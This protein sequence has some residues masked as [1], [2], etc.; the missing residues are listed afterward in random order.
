MKKL[1]V[2]SLTLFLVGK[3]FAQ[4]SVVSKSN[5][6]RPVPKIGHM[7]NYMTKPSWKN[8]SFIDSVKALHLEIIRYPGGTE[9]QYFD[10]QT[11]SSVPAFLWLNGTL[12]SHRYI[13]TVP[14]LS[15]PLSELLYFYQQ[16]GVKPIFCLNLLTKDLANQLVML[17]SAKNMGIPVEYIELGNEL[18]FTDTDFIN[19]YPNPI[20]YVSDV[21]NNWLP[22]LKNAFPDAKIAIIGSYDGLTDLNGNN[23]PKRIHT[24]N[25]TVFAQNLNSNAI[26]FHYY[27]PPNTTTL[28]NPNISQAL[29][30]PFRHWKTLKANTVDKVTNGMEC[31]VTEYNLNDGNQTN[32][33][34]ASSWTHG[35]YTA[36][37]YGLMLEEPKITMLL[38]H[39]ITGSPAFASLASYTPFGDTLSNKMTAE[40]NAMR[41][42]HKSIKG[43]NT[44][45]KL[46]FSNN[47]SITVG[48]AVYPS[49][50]GWIFEEDSEKELFILNL[51]NTS[52]NLNFSAIFDD[53][54]SYEQITATN[55]LQKNI[56]TQNLTISKGV[57]N[58]SFQSLPYSLVYASKNTTITGIEDSIFDENIVIYPNPSDKKIILTSTLTNLHNNSFKIVDF[59]GKELIKGEI[60][61]NEIDISQLSIG[62]FILQVEIERGKYIVRKIV[63]K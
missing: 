41:L 56:T 35:L 8:Q 45:T 7:L 12:F 16:T 17:Q 62:I 20:D 9:S 15:Y 61:G 57:A 19:K 4:T 53:S 59:V 54:F 60:Q 5:L 14:H 34:I 43:K 6:T 52:F 33:A 22:Q 38:N 47:P 50:M 27:L 2:I 40:G 46:D 39:Q 58:S 1:L 25:N 49:L 3:L 10:W 21:K 44:A 23:T 30:A 32:Y 63:K 48:A 31:W 55:P 13:G 51:S 11:G 42:L 18:Y 29:A 37:L 26:T 36:S 28:S 24:W